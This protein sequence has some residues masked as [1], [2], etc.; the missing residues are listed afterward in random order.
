MKRI[1]ITGAK[2]YIG[3]NVRN[4]LFQYPDDYFVDVIDT[5][6]LIAKPKIFSPYDVVFNVAGIAHI[7]ET[8]E[9]RHLY[10]D[11]NRDLAIKIAQ[12]AKEAGVRQFIVLSSM[13]VYGML[14]GHITKDTIPAPNTAYGD[15]KFQA[16]EEI[17]RLVDERFKFACLR[18]P[19]VYGNG[20]KGNYQ[21]LR[22]FALKS[23]V[24][25]KYI[26]ERSMV[27]IGNLCEFVKSVIDEERNGLFFPQN[28][29]YVKTS[30]MVKLIAEE[31]GKKIRLTKAFNWLIKIVPV[32][33]IKRLFGNLTYEPVDLVSKYGFKDT[34]EM[35]ER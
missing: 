24:F 30:E 12:A 9:N 13:S 33:T 32:G 15:S 1:L 16:D 2:S 14:T 11:V 4:Y 17:K 19:M 7:K 29:E 3:E 22:A 26:N 6:D 5:M 18:P 31:N 25:P 23:P 35:T 27:Y 10:Y 21:R 20:C 34:V 28:A 8:A